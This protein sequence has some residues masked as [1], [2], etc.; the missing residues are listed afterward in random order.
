MQL[1][2]GSIPVISC[3]EKRKQSEEIN[4]DAHSP[5]Q[6]PSFPFSSKKTLFKCSTFVLSVQS[7]HFIYSTAA[8][9]I[10][11]KVIRSTVMKLYLFL[12][13]SIKKNVQCC[14]KNGELATRLHRCCST[15]LLLLAGSDFVVGKTWLPLRLI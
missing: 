6:G 5:Q 2:F 8:I 13:Y 3:S 12:Y 14:F 11:L 7:A 4:L 15:S 9:C 1:H 10:L